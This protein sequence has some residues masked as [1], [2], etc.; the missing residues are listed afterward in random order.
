MAVNSTNSTS[1]TLSQATTTSTNPKGI[2]GKDDFLKLLLVELQYQ[3]PTAPTDTEQ[4]LTQ[5]AQLASLESA[6]N[7]NAALEKLSASLSSSQQFSTIAAIGKTADLGTDAI[8]HDKGNST[9]FEVYFPEDIQEGTVS[10]TDNDGNIIRT[11]DVGT[12]SKGVYQFTWDGLNNG[13]ESVE[14]AIYHVNAAYNDPSGN[15]LQTRLGAYQI[16]SVRF[17]NGEA[18]LKVGSNYVTLDNIQEIY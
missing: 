3:D 18:E 8:A 1:S 5:T 11:L 9:T 10:I 2:L 7:T 12:N 14:S 15:A 16:E 17:S 6:D 13:G 4:I